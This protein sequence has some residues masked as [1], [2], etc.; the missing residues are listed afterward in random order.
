MGRLNFAGINDYDERAAG[1]VN[2]IQTAFV[3]QSA[4][5]DG[6]N[7]RDEAFSARHFSPGAVTNVGT[8]LNY[9]ES[10]SS[11]GIT[12]NNVAYS[13]IDFS[14]LGA[15]NDVMRLNNNGAGWTLAS[16]MES[17]RIRAAMMMTTTQ[18]GL[19]AYFQLFHDIGAGYVAVTGTE[20]QYTLGNIG[21]VWVVY[22]DTFGSYIVG[23]YR[24]DYSFTWLLKGPATISGIELHSKQAPGAGNRTLKWAAFQAV[25]FKR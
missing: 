8:P 15:G 6:D 10:G 4:T 3:N 21:G 12:I 24:D 16:D 19:T 20:Q 23:G 9:V 17:L 1:T 22:G 5:L 13:V 14:G 2:A 7:F 18:V 11:T 25:H